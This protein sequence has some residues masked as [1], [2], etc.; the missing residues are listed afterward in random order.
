MLRRSLAF[1]SSALLGL[2]GAGC[3]GLG[4]APVVADAGAA[5]ATSPAAATSDAGI[6]DP[7]LR[8]I[9]LDGGALP[10][11]CPVGG[12]PGICR[13]SPTCTMPDGCPGVRVCEDGA[14]SSCDYNGTGS[15]SCSHNGV[16]GTRACTASGPA[17]SCTASCSACGLFG[18]TTWTEGSS[19]GWSVCNI[20]ANR[21]TTAACG[22]TQGQYSCESDQLVCRFN[23]WFGWAPNL[24]ITA[25]GLAGL[26]LCTNG[27]DGLCRAS[28]VCNGYDDDLDGVVDNQ[29][30]SSVPFSVVPPTCPAGPSGGCAPHARTCVAGALS[31]CNYSGGVSCVSSC[32]GQPSIAAC[33]PSTGTPGQCPPP[34]EVCNGT[35]DNCD[36]NID[37]GGVCMQA[38]T[39]SP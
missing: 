12:C 32:R 28:E 6:N 13:G 38:D 8:R 23:A 27:G 36:G 31:S 39:C 10:D 29:P 37:E 16:T 11:A 5:G 22:S 35:D 34:P 15:I 9:T 7:P 14:W 18:T 30:G 17:T 24:C 1:A 3:G 26:A 19:T 20:G 25:H 2:A 21:C 33:D 4:G